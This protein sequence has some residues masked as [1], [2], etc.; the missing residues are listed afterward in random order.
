M[1]DRTKEEYVTMVLASLIA[2]GGA[3]SQMDGWHACGPEC[4][5][6]ALTSGDVEILEY[7]YP[8]IIH[9]YSLMTDSGGAGKNR[10][11]SGTIWEVE[12]IGHEMT[13]VTFGE[14]RKIA[15]AGAAGALNTSKLNDRKV[16]RII[17]KKADGTEDV[18]RKNVILT[19]GPGETCANAN[20][21]GGGYGDPFERDMAK[22]ADDVKNGLVSV[23]AAGIEYGVVVD[24][25]TLVADEAA[26]AKLR[27]RGWAEAG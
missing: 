11:G 3:T 17:L 13:V 20:P 8:I 10:G 2:G 1:D 15:A 18:L 26:S 12:P 21:G 4:C 23:E 9:R 16:G 6:G 5:F 27:A 22:V 24:P 25:A 19:I 14:G 7:S